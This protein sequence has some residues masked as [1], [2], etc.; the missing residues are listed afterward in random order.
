M[1]PR[2]PCYMLTRMVSIPVKR[3]CIM[4][5]RMGSTSV[6]RI[7]MEIIWTHTTPTSLAVPIKVLKK[8]IQV[9]T[10]SLRLIGELS[11]PVKTTYIMVAR[12]GNILVESIFLET[13]QRST[14]SHTTHGNFFTTHVH[15]MTANTWMP[16][17]FRNHVKATLNHGLS[18]TEVDWGDPKR[19]STKHGPSL[20]E[21]DWGGKIEP[22]HTTSECVLSEVDC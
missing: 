6:G 16:S 11:I 4:V 14:S 18:L 17:A 15:L 7:F 13:I 19:E 5:I 2:I 12:I 10:C 22:N 21:V 8:Y 9:E 1:L 20:M 3:T